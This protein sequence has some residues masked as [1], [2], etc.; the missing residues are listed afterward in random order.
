MIFVASASFAT[1]GITASELNKMG[2]SDVRCKDNKV[3]FSG[4]LEDA[5]RACI[6]LRSAD[7]VG[8]LV[9]SFGAITFD[10]LFDGIK[11]IKWSNYIPRNAKIIVDARCVKSKLMS[12]RDVQ[13]LSK[14]A[15]IDSLSS[16]YK[17]T[18][19]PETGYEIYIN[20][21]ILKDEVNVIIDLCGEGLHK[22][23]Y[24]L[25][26]SE[27]PIRETLAASLLL[28]CDNKIEY[29]LDPF[30]GS[31]TLA[32]EAAMI[33]GNIAPGR[34]RKFAADNYIF[35]SKDFKRQK[36]RAFEAPTCDD[37]EI[38][39]SDIDSNMVEITKY[40]ASR[41][42]VNIN[43]SC[44]NAL[45]YDDIYT[46]NGTMVTNPPY[47][48]RILDLSKAHELMT[49]FSGLVNRLIEQYWEIGVITPDFDLE[50]A[51]CMQSVSKRK[52]FNA[53]IQCTYYQ[54][55]NNT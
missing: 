41:A 50:K 34:N 21:S 12:Q 26:S 51:F 16:S 23:G 37:Y 55:K 25:L 11:C 33:A 10:Q 7:R 1:E 30:C 47:G 6:W 42:G 54:F 2:M 18:T 48:E 19:F 28:L 24:R 35:A 49:D 14:K 53:N 43:V 8:L 31:G 15:I 5:A 52:L 38:L 46:Y 44:R 29:F 20:V 45:D 36:E 17:I 40:H 9:S 3:Y 32:I 13:R 22:R 27:A 4:K 39:C